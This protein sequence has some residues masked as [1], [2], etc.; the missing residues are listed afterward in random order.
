MPTGNEIEDFTAITILKS[1][2]Q[3]PQSVYQNNV[4]IPK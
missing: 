3:I 1:H 2:L 4:S